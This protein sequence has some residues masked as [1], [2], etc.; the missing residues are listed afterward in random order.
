MSR[1]SHATVRVAVV[2][3]D[4]LIVRRVREVLSGDAITTAGGATDVAGLADDTGKAAAIVMAGWE[5]PMQCRAL[6]REATARFPHVPIVVIGALSPSGIHKALEAG[7]LGFVLDSE[8][9]TT[10]AATIR[11]VRA[12]QVVVPRQRRHAAVHR[13]LSHREKQALALLAMGLTNRQIASQLFLAESTVKS[14]LTS[15]FEKLGV[16]SR[17]EAAELVLDPAQN[18]GL[19]TLGPLPATPAETMLE[20]LRTW[21]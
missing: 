6:V 16:R 7:A 10:L 8:V 19:G 5:G 20:E 17:S 2:A 18:F 12:G 14:H 21:K 4:E 1:P 13:A 11:A 3:M 15:I 9:E